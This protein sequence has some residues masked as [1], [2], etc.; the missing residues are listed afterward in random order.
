MGRAPLRFE[1]TMTQRRGKQSSADQPAQRQKR[2]A[3]PIAV[4]CLLLNLRKVGF[5]FAQL[6]LSAALAKFC[7]KP[8]SRISI[9]FTCIARLTRRKNVIRGEIATFGHRNKVFGG[10]IHSGQKSLLVSAINAAMLP[11]SQAITPIYKCK[12]TNCI[13][14][15][16]QVFLS[17]KSLFFGMGD[18]PFLLIPLYLVRVFFLPLNCIKSTIRSMRLI[19][20]LSALTKNWPAIGV[21][22]FVFFQNNLPIVSKILIPLLSVATQT[23]LLYPIGLTLV[24]LQFCA[25]LPESTATTYSADGEGIIQHPG[26]SFAGFAKIVVDGAA[27]QAVRA[28]SYTALV[29]N[30]NYTINKERIYA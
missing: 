18:S 28:G 25:G 12:I 6:G 22:Y 19:V 23:Q 1:G 21:V 30:L 15:M 8:Y 3:A 13:G 11:I 16:G 2:G 14:F 9:Q 7:S 10:Q 27:K 24:L 26:F 4:L 29:H 20:V 17:A 5:D